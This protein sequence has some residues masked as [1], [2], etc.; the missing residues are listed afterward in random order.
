MGVGIGQCQK[1]RDMPV[2][3]CGERLR[4]GAVS[5]DEATAERHTRRFFDQGRAHGGT[6]SGCRYPARER[7][8]G[9]LV[10]FDAK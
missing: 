1:V 10:Q 2:C 8:A 6:H 5:L 7:F 4:P 9:H 3:L